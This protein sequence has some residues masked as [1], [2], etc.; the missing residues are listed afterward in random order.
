MPE[1]CSLTDSG[2]Y[3]VHHNPAAYYT[4]IRSDCQSQDV[5]LA[6]SPDISAP[7]T[8]ITPDNCHNMH[9][10]PV[11]SGDAWLATWLPTIL[12]SRTYAAGDTVVFLTW[13]EAEK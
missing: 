1:N 3:V 11:S 7:F 8:F 10:C 12:T 4:T 2:D 13:D 9:S 5:P 6:S